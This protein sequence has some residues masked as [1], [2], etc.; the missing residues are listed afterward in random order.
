M[1]R[2]DA[3]IR[4]PLPVARAWA[5]LA[6]PQTVARCLPGARLVER[7]DVEHRAVVEARSRDGIALIT[8]TLEPA[9]ASTQVLADAD[10]GAADTLGEFARGAG[11]VLT[12]AASGAGPER[13]GPDI[14]VVGSAPGRWR[15][16]VALSVAAGAALAVLGAVLARGARRRR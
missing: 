2:A 14:P 15:P 8:L 5:V 16:V 6:D 9:G 3:Q 1:T 7:D 12:S 13:T 10:G 11:Q 4:V